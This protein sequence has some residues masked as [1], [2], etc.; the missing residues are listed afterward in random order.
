MLE[1][2]LDWRRCSS[3]APRR[4]GNKRNGDMATSLLG[5]GGVRVLRLSSR[6]ELGCLPPGCP[7]CSSS[8]CRLSFVRSLFFR[9]RRRFLLALRV[10]REVRF[11]FLFFREPGYPGSLGVFR[12]HRCHGI[13]VW[14]RL[15]SRIGTPFPIL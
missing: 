6:S 2:P 10:A 8:S 11:P 14:R 5:R 4:T 9:L 3:R 13:R 7:R 12:R 1:S 15:R